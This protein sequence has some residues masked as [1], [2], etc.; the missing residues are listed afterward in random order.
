MLCVCVFVCLCTFVRV[1][2]ISAL[3]DYFAA[4]L[5]KIVYSQR[6]EERKS[7]RQWWNRVMLPWWFSNHCHSAQTMLQLEW[8]Q[9]TLKFHSDEITSNLQKMKESPA[10]FLLTPF[11]S[12][13]EVRIPLSSQFCNCRLFPLSLKWVKRYNLTETAGPVL[14]TESNNRLIKLVETMKSL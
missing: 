10:I 7:P 14:E 1:Q 4:L 9:A 3:Q 8:S 6:V 5:P 12:G 13:W 2:T 11:L